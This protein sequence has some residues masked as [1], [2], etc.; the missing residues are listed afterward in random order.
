MGGDQKGRS[1][2]FALLLFYCV[3]WCSKLPRCWEK[4]HEEHDC[5]TPFACPRCFIS[6]DMPDSLPSNLE[7]SPES[8]RTNI[9][10]RAHAPKLRPEFCRMRNLLHSRKPAEE[11]SHTDPKGSAEL[12]EPSP[13]FS[14]LQCNT[15]ASLRCF[16]VSRWRA[17]AGKLEPTKQARDG[18]EVSLLIHDVY[19]MMTCD[20]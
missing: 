13:A 15:D 14:S 8:V 16:C 10:R 1:V 20:M 11:A 18:K 2:I 7:R 6:F 12:W 3:F 9:K 19:S 5:Q 4:Q 17:T